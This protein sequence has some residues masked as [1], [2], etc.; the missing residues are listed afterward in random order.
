MLEDFG[1]AVRLLSDGSEFDWIGF[2]DAPTR[3][4]AGVSQELDFLEPAPSVLLPTS[5]L[6]GF[7]VGSRIQVLEGP[8]AGDYLARSI[9]AEEDG[10]FSRVDLAD[11]S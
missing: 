4:I 9:V 5:A 3:E 10:V 2:F 8:G 6:A 1:V 7:R 11:A